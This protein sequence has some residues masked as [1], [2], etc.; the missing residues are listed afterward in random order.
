MSDRAGVL[1][2]ESANYPFGSPRNEFRPQGGRED[3]QFTQ[4]ERDVESGLAYFEARFLV[5]SFGRFNRVDPLATSMEVAG[6]AVP[7]RLNI[8]CYARGNPV[9][10]VDPT[11]LLDYDLLLSGATDLALGVAAVGLAVG[12]AVVAAP[13]GLTAAAAVAVT[14]GIFGGGASIGYGV[15]GLAAGATLD[16][17]SRQAAS[18]VRARDQG[19]DI[20]GAM[21]DAVDPLSWA[22]RVVKEAVM[23]GGGTTK[24]ASVLKDVVDGLVSARGL[25]RGKFD[26]DAAHR[27]IK[28]GQSLVNDLSSDRLSLATEGGVIHGG[29]SNPEMAMPSLPGRQMPSIPSRASGASNIE[30]PKIVEIKRVIE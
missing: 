11:G 5:S 8:Y 26:S 16:P 1:V 15:A 7:Q 9:R 14:G 29:T 2:E 23:D 4:K 19:Q 10:F 3:Y 22:G 20:T 30:T 28:A 6:I 27:L 13:V 24:E 12:V 18:F 25:V 17:G 21:E